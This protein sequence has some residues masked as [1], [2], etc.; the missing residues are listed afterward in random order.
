MATGKAAEAAA[1]VAA[2][3]ADAGG[4]EA[5]AAAAREAA[6]RL[7]LSRECSPHTSRLTGSIKQTLVDDGC[8]SCP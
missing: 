6:G 5:G 1:A 7:S 8:G 2:A 3:D 4:E